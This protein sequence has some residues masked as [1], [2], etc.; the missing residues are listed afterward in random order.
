MKNLTSGV[1]WKAVFF[2]MLRT[3]GVIVAPYI[4]TILYTQDWL[5]VA[6]V[7]GFAVLGSFLT[8][9]AGLAESEGK[10]VVWYYALFE[11]AIKTAAQAIL[12]FI[13][14]ATMFQDVAWG[15]ALPFV[16]TAVLGSLLIAVMGFLPE[17]DEKRPLAV[18]STNVVVIN[19]QGK[20]GEQKVPVAAVTP[21]PNIE[22]APPITGD[23]NSVG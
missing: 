6:S 12:T 8:S 9:L 14:T 11:R 17:T 13:G 20:E 2:R 10:T 23:P 4:P 22:A 7:V 19:E 18:A 3:A 1:W 15:D 21:A 5:I 16:G